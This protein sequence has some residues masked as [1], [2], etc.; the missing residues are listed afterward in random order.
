MIDYFNINNI[1]ILSERRQAGYFFFAD[2]IMIETEKKEK[3]K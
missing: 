2:Y 3:Q 1:D